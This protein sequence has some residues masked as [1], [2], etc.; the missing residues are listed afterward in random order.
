MRSNYKST[1]AHISKTTE[2]RAK[3]LGRGLAIRR[4]AVADASHNPFL[5]KGPDGNLIQGTL[6]T[7]PDIPIYAN[8]AIDAVLV[9]NGGKLRS[10][11]R[12]RISETVKAT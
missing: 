9:K 2:A 1:V 3:L 10:A 5:V 12:W 4:R 7:V 8:A 11:I 6:L